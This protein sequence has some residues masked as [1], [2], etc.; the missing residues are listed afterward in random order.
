MEGRGEKNTIWDGTRVLM[1]PSTVRG[2]GGV[3]CLG[4]VCA[5]RG[6]T[7]CFGKGNEGLPSDTKAEGFCLHPSTS[8]MMG[9]DFF[10]RTTKGRFLRCVLRNRSCVQR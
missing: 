4:L 2:R 1:V 8:V 3:P 5:E 10:V 9:P 6:P 7:E